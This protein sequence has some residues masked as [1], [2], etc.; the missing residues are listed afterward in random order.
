[1]SGLH[2]F[3]RDIINL[4]YLVKFAEVQFGCRLMERLILVELVA[5]CCPDDVS[6]HAFLSYE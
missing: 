6:V 1:M 3:V 2:S 5:V 4:L